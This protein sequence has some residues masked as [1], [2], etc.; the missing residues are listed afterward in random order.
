MKWIYLRDPSQLRAELRENGV[1]LR[2]DVC[3]EFR[4]ELPCGGV[5]QDSREFN[6]TEGRQIRDVMDT[7]V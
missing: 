4:L 5:Q 1:L 7:E 3:M 2:L 6:W